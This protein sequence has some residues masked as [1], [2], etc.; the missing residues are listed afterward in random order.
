MSLYHEDNEKLTNVVEELIKAI[1]CKDYSVVSTVQRDHRGAVN[2]GT[3]CKHSQIYRPEAP[4]RKSGFHLK[5][6]GE[7]VKGVGQGAEIRTLTNAC[8]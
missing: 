5:C 4:I 2:F 7:E 1:L 6:E 3:S 8:P